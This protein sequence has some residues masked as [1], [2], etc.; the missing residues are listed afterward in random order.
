MLSKNIVKKSSVGFLE[1]L[2]LRVQ[3]RLIGFP[4]A[5]AWQKVQAEYESEFRKFPKLR[6]IEVSNVNDQATFR[7]LEEMTPDLVMVSGTNLVGSKLIRIIQKRCPIMNLHT[8]I[9]PYIKGGPNCTNWCL[10]IDRPDLIGNTVMWLDAGIDSGEIITTE[11]TPLFKNESLVKLY[12]K[13]LDHA[14]DLY[15]RTAF[16]FLTN[17]KKPPKVNQ[18]SLGKGR[19]FYTRD[20]NFHAMINARKNFNKHFVA[21]GSSPTWPIHDEQ[22]VSLNELE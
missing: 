17:P 15:V 1:G 6:T 13:V 11:R 14:H 18:D 19:T 16:V 9:S 5:Q 8:G 3:N 4:L 22:L 10:A 2:S 21:T 12:R 7:F 20:W